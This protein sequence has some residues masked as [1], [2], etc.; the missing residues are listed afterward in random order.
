M[1]EKLEELGWSIIT[2]TENF[3]IVARTESIGSAEKKAELFQLMFTGFY[4]FIWY[5]A[6]KGH[7]YFLRR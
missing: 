7:Y 3:L 4:E 6:F 5:D 2:K 1:E